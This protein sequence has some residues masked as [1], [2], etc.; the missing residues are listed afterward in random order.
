[1]LNHLP[2]AVSIFRAL[3]GPV[4]AWLLL[5]SASASVESEAVAYG[6]ASGV[7]FVVAAA[8][9]W[10]DGW[11]ARRMGVVSP[12]GALLDPIADKLLVGPYL[13]AYAVISAF[14]PW[15]T[16]P[17][18]IVV[19]RDM[20]VTG[21]RLRQ[22]SGGSLSVSAEAKTKTAIQMVIVAAPFVLVI[23]GLRDVAVWFY[24]WVGAVWFL[25]VLTVWT[26]LPYLRAARRDRSAQD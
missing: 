23:A 25:A 14:D 22:P 15:L 19:I 18:A 26:A 12:L 8:S 5:M 24:P 10:L 7:L 21:L 1:M 9:D 17:V 13:I 20:V 6:L 3:A 2:N 11:L 4:G 16:V